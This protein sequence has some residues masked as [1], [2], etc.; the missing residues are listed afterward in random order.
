M[1]ASTLPTSKVEL[2]AA[3][4]HP[5]GM[6]ILSHASVIFVCS[7]WW[8]KLAT[9]QLFMPLKY[10]LSF[11]IESQN[12]QVFTTE[13]D[14]FATLF[15]V[16]LSLPPYA[17]PAATR[18]TI[19]YYEILQDAQVKI[20]QILPFINQVYYSIRLINAITFLFLHPWPRK[21][22]TNHGFFRNLFT[23]HGRFPTAVMADI[24]RV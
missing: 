2:A 18:I 21:L 14:P 1:Y 24:G 9:R 4:V 8:T 3:G 11:R 10:T 6:M 23:P 16:I 15:P 13:F 20:S 17:T 5:V 22:C 12:S 19:N 7:V